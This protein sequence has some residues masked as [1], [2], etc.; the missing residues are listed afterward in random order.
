M[1]NQGLFWVPQKMSHPSLRLFCF[2][3]AGGSSSTYFPWVNEFFPEVELVLI[4]PPGRGARIAESPH[5]TMKSFID[6]MMFHSSF[7]TELPSVYFGHSL[8]SRV[9]YQLCREL[10]KQNYR[11]PQCLFVSGSRAAHLASGRKKEYLLT[12]ESFKEELRNLNGTPKLVLENDQLMELLL[13]AL[14]SDF[15]ISD[16]FSSTQEKL[17]LKIVALYGSEDMIVSKEQVEAW[18]QLSKKECEFIEISGDHFF[19]ESNRRETILVV[20][21]MLNDIHRKT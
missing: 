6:E 7:L 19:I 13:P 2:P 21:K 17:N 8:G 1:K 18:Q 16:T 11:I 15:R 4:Q 5:K 10:D 12:D 14:K 9:A 20:K 3:Y